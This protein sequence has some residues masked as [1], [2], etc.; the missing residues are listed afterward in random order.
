MQCI[1]R[2]YESE[3]IGKI[4]PC[5]GHQG[6]ATREVTS[7]ALAHDKGEGESDRNAE[8]G[9]V[10]ACSVRMIVG[11]GI[12]FPEDW[13]QPTVA[14][15]RLA[16]VCSFAS[17]GTV[18]GNALVEGC[19]EFLYGE[20]AL[21][22]VGLSYDKTSGDEGRSPSREYFTLGQRT[23]KNVDGVLRDIVAAEVQP[24]EASDRGEHRKVFDV[25]ELGSV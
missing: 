7:N 25:P 23:T 24:P 10:F 3:S 1:P 19:G 21:R 11:H 2:E 5:V 17:P 15:N 20:A 22:S 16:R 6:Q 9:I 4:V 12:P 8:T 18:S 13:V 14:G